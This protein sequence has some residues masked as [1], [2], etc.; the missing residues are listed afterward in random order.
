MY[1]PTM[2]V[3]GNVP[4]CESV[5]IAEYMDKNLTEAKSLMFNQPDWVKERYEQFKEKHEGEWDVEGYTFG[6]LQTI[7]Y[8]R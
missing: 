4:V 1:I 6:H 2:T 8:V 5:N 7:W 3:Q